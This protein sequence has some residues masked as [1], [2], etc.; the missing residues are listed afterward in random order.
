MKD[1]LQKITDDIRADLAQRGYGLYTIAHPELR[2]PL[3]LYIVPDG[4]TARL[5]RVKVGER[6][7]FDT[8]D[9]L[10]VHHDDLISGLYV[11]LRA[12][13]KAATTPPARPS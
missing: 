10:C 8:G 7:L 11:F 13:I 6:V 9:Q 3:E 1:N 2:D 4:A 5:V 12:C